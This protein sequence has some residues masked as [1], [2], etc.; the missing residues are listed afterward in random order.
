LLGGGGLALAAEDLALGGGDVAGGHVDPER[1][2]DVGLDLGR[3]GVPPQ[4][5]QGPPDGFFLADAA[6]A[7]LRGVALVRHGGLRVGGAGDATPTLGPEPRVGQPAGA[8]KTPDRSGVGPHPWLFSPNR[9]RLSG[10][11]LAVAPGPGARSQV[12]Q[13]LW[14]R[15]PSPAWTLPGELV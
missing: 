9:T 11:G 15:H 8:A 3:L 4:L 13:L 5:L 10:G 2:L 14:G 1:L 7:R 6:A 12:E